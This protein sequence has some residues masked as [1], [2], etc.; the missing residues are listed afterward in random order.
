[1]LRK[2]VYDGLVGSSVLRRFPYSDSVI[3]GRDF[4]DLR[5]SRLR[6]DDHRDPSRHSEPMTQSTPAINDIE[7][8]LFNALASARVRGAAGTI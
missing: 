8:R 5:F 3:D 4:D 1:M 2:Q 6:F 7:E